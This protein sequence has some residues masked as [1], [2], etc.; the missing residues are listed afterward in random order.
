MNF[1]LRRREE[2]NCIFCAGGELPASVP[3]PCDS[4]YA[5]STFKVQSGPAFS[6][7]FTESAQ[8]ILMLINLLAWYM[9]IAEEYQQKR[10]TC[11][12]R[13]GHRMGH[14]KAKLPV[15][16]KKRHSSFG[17]FWATKGTNRFRRE[18]RRKRC[19]LRPAITTVSSLSRSRKAKLGK[20]IRE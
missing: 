7:S 8:C 4:R 1:E 6:H 18:G 16:T 9:Q 2:T 15:R 20:K 12:E 14:G 3:R 11:S 10:P 19:F 13:V 17:T 5:N